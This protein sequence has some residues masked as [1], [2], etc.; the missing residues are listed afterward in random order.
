MYY[1]KGESS[2]EVSIT[3]VFKDVAMEDGDA[4][5][6]EHLDYHVV[7]ITVGNGDSAIQV[8]DIDEDMPILSIGGVDL[9]WKTSAGFEVKDGGGG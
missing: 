6:P 4:P 8:K 9:L 3:E 1:N 7:R 5:F 2:E